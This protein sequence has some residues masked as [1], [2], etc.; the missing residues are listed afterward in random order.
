MHVAA[1]IL[2]PANTMPLLPWGS[3]F[4][5]CGLN[6]WVKGYNHGHPMDEKGGLLGLAGCPPL[7]GCESPISLHHAHLPTPCWFREGPFPIEEQNHS[8]IKVHQWLNSSAGIK[9]LA[10]PIAVDPLKS[11][12]AVLWIMRLL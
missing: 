8:W 11:L 12:H 3:M 2:S 1:A 9:F 10:L 7:V 4:D 6:V 5:L